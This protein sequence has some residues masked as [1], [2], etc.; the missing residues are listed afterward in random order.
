[1]VFALA[2]TGIAA[3]LAAGLIASTYVYF[4]ARTSNF[5][6]ASFLKRLICRDVSEWVPSDDT[7]LLKEVIAIEAQIKQA[8][9]A[10]LSKAFAESKVLF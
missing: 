8:E 6:P 3:N 10:K 7:E 2:A 5:Q 9:V 4:L 1:M